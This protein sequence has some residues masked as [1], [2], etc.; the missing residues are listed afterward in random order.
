MDATLSAATPGTQIA[1]P[2]STVQAPGCDELR[3]AAN[4]PISRWY[5]RP[6]AGRLAALL[7]ESPVRPWHL[8]LANLV[9]AATAGGVL[10]CE[11]SLAPFAGLLVL[12]AWFCDRADGQLARRQQTASRKGAWLDANIDELV[13]LGL[14]LA[15]AAAA[16][17]LGST[18]AWPLCMAFLAGK[19]LLMYGL[20]VEMPDG[21]RGR[22]S[23]LPA[24]DVCHGRR[25][26]SR[27][28][29]LPIPFVP[30]WLK[31]AYHLPGNADVR[32]HLL[33]AALLGGWLLEELALVAAYYNLRW[34]TRY[35]LVL[36]R[37]ER[38]L[39]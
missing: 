39:A 23:F 38:G 10:I 6:W 2:R 32:V 25:L 30:R 37:T 24:K 19:Y 11:P 22:E 36:L 13:D 17:A 26:S 27:Q 33:M 31:A 7:A 12:A 3:R 20:L 29:R 35:G 5:V 15:V 28:K 4:Y 16:T 8:T 34:I 1:I 18:W 9:F 21:Q 14:H